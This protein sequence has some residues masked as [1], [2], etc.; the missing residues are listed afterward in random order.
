MKYNTLQLKI[1]MKFYPVKLSVEF[2]YWIKC[3]YA[4]EM[5][6]SKLEA[7]KWSILRIFTRIWFSTAFCKIC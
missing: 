5:L 1:D 6:T 2:E 4:E 7:Q 3:D